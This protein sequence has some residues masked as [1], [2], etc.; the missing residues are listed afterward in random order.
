M[1]KAITLNPMITY[2]DENGV[3]SDPIEKE[4]TLTVTEQESL[5]PG[6]DGSGE[7]PAVTE[8]EGSSKYGKFVIPAVIAVLVIGT[9]GTVVVLKR[10][11]K[12]KE[13]E[14][15]EALE[16]EEEKDNEI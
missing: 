1:E 3:V 7:F 8:P 11:K 4:I 9:I 12:K 13:A 15:L 14:A 10:R 2:E 16:P 5:D 6:M